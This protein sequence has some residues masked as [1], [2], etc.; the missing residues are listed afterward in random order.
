MLFNEKIFQ[1]IFFS[2]TQRKKTLKSHWISFLAYVQW[3]LNI[4]CCP[5]SMKIEHQ[6]F[7]WMEYNNFFTTKCWPSME[8]VVPRCSR[9]TSA[10]G[11]SVIIMSIFHM[12]FVWVYLLP[13]IKSSSSSSSSRDLF[14]GSRCTMFWPRS[15]SSISISIGSTDQLS[16]NRR[17]N[18]STFCIIRRFCC[19]PIFVHN[20]IEHL[21]RRVHLDN[22]TVWRENIL[23][24]FYSS[25]QNWDWDTKFEVKKSNHK[26]CSF[27]YHG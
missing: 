16:I 19:F 3:K 5:C 7:L 27:S 8:I 1:N 10:L 11:D 25:D 20:K 14:I 17:P 23:S 12:K 15:I 13:P 24:Y 22:S 9:W 6:N 18:N 2:N 26:K 4:N 21:I